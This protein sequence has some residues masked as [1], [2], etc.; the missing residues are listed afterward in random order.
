MIDHVYISV[1]DPERSLAFYSAALAPLGYRAFGNY[2]SASGPDSVPN[3]WGL[4]SGASSIWLRQRLAGETGLYLGLA[5]SNHSAVD[6]TF[7]AALAAGGTDDC[8]PAN[9]IYFAD[10]YYAA[11]VID[12]DDNRL[13]IVNKS[14]S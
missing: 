9:R 5:A 3:L 12:L 10:G 2:D 8:K 11:N 4:N 7:E 14:W 13:E 1:S 6:A